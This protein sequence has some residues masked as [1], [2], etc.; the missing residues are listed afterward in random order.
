MNPYT[1]NRLNDLF[2][3]ILQ[4]KIHLAKYAMLPTSNTLS[5]IFEYV[6][7]DTLYTDMCNCKVSTYQHQNKY[8]RRNYY[9]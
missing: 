5:E 6:E 8:R 7:K 3:K 1:R 9:Y 2:I 4:D